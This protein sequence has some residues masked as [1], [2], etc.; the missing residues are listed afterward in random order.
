[1]LRYCEANY[2]AGEGQ[3]EGSHGSVI[4]PHLQPRSHETRLSS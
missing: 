1:M 3:K 4:E 2:P